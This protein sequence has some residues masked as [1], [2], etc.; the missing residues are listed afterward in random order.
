[1]IYDLL[2]SYTSNISIMGSKVLIDSVNNK[3]IARC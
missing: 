3:P 1:M 2:F